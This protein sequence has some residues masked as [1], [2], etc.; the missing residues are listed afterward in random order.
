MANHSPLCRK[1]RTGADWGRVD[2]AAG[3]AELG[4]DLSA[5]ECWLHVRLL[6]HFF[7]SSTYILFPLFGRHVLFQ[8]RNG[9]ENLA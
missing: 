9:L 7:T 8:D 6:Y 5:P 2:A 4:H 3:S 1:A